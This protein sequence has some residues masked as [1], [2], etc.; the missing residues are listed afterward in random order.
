MPYGLVIV[1]TEHVPSARAI[2]ESA[3]DLPAEVAEKQFVPAGSPTGDKPATYWWLA[4]KFS[5][6]QWLE[7]QQLVITIGW[8]RIEAYDI[9]IEPLKPWVILAEMGLKPLK[10]EP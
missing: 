7:L 10:S 4:T 9:D 3:F 6:S 2:A 1:P 8:G 5:D